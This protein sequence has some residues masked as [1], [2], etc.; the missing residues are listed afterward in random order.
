MKKIIVPV[1]LSKVS[2]NALEYALGLFGENAEYTV[3]HAM[4]GLMDLN[5]GFNPAVFEAQEDALK[6]RITNRILEVMGREELPANV[7]VEILVGNIIPRI[8][9]R[10]QEGGFDAMVIGTRDKYDIVDRWFG[11][12][13]LAMVKQLDM[14]IYLIPIYS[15]YKGFERVMVAGDNALK[16]SSTIVDIARWNQPHQAFLTFL[17]VAKDSKDDFEEEREAIIG[18]LLEKEN[19]SFG[20]DVTTIEGKNVSESLLGHAYNDHTDLMIVQPEHHSFLYTLLFRSVSRDLITQSNIPILFLP[21]CG[22][23]KKEDVEWEGPQVE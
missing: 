15:Q 14:P 16:Q 21:Q 19:H 18:G 13:T 5:D 11:T 8:A 1:D 20:F 10:A 23:T 6:R 4:D 7:E 2:A 17:H 12:V 22:D 9:N 3:V